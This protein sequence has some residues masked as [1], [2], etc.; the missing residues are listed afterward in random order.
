MT[1]QHTTATQ[2]T[3]PDNTAVR[4]ALWRALHV[5]V[6]APPHVLVDGGGSGLVDAAR[7]GRLRHHAAGGRRLRRRDHVSVQGDDRHDPPPDRRAR[8]RLDGRDDL[9]GTSRTARR[10]CRPRRARGIQKRR[11]VLEHTVRQFLHARRD[12]DARPRR[13]FHRR[14]PCAGNAMCRERS[15]PRATSPAATTACARP[16]A[17]N[18]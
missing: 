5:Q 15:S 2:R 11:A 16:A 9:P 4:T 7:R 1:D 8:P 12:A 18:S 3:V 17:R 13:R 6:D 10:R 14:A